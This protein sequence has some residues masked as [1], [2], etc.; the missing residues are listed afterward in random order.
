LGGGDR[1]GKT[2]GIHSE[3]TRRGVAKSVAEIWCHSKPPGKCNRPDLLR[4]DVEGPSFQ[5]SACNLGAEG[6]Q[7]RKG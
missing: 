7:L 3:E 4:P 6:A 1:H 2:K 5:R